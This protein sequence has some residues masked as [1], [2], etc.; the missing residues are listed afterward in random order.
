MGLCAL[1][2]RTGFRDFRDVASTCPT[3]FPAYCFICEKAF[4]HLSTKPA[5]WAVFPSSSILCHC[6]DW[7]SGVTAYVLKNKLSALLDEFS[8]RLVRRQQSI[9][10]LLVKQYS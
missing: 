1:A 3:H 4:S 6:A 9:V 5:W 7:Y 10:G 8:V 2:C